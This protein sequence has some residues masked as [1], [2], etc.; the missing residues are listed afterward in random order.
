MITLYELI[1]GQHELM[2]RY[3]QA[4]CRI[5]DTIQG[6]GLDFFACSGIRNDILI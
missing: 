6:L 2:M 1:L 4:G 3:V 5:V